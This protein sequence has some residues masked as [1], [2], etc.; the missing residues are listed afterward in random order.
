[1][2]IFLIFSYVSNG[3]QS[4]CSVD[5]SRFSMMRTRLRVCSAEQL[6]TTI[7]DRISYIADDCSKHRISH[8]LVNN[9]QRFHINVICPVLEISLK[10]FLHRLC[11]QQQCRR[12]P[13]D[14]GSLDGNFHSLEISMAQ[15]LSF[16]P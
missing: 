7:D 3:N 4:S 5:C 8:E 11:R 6:V 9:S 12:R 1:M 16:S 10:L 2:P 13:L 15:R 14:L